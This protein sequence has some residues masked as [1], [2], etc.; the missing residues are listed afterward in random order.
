MGDS[1]IEGGSD[2]SGGDDHSI[3]H[4]GNSFGCGNDGG[5]VMMEMLEMWMVGMVLV[6][7]M[8]AVIRVR[9]WW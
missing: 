2:G 4:G 8:L 3:D 7:K 5:G 9:G 6:A 1:D